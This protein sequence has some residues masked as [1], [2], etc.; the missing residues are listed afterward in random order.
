MGGAPDADRSKPGGGRGRPLVETPPL[1]PACWPAA[2]CTAESGTTRSTF[3]QDSL[4]SGMP[5]ANPHC[6]IN[7]DGDASAEIRTKVFRIGAPLLRST[8][9]VSLGRSGGYDVRQPK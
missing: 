2:E 9:P 1:A 7:T 8:I 3:L 6:S 5:Q 4:M